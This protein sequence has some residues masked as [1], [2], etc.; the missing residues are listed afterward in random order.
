MGPLIRRLPSGS[1]IAF[2]QQAILPKSQEVCSFPIP[3]AVLTSR[4]S[5]IQFLR[6]P[7]LERNP[8]RGLWG[9]KPDTPASDSW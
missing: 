9:H 1:K 3:P 8:G 4:V 5:G 2:Q 6:T 7:P